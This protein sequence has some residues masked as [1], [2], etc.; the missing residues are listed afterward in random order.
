VDPN[1]VRPPGAFVVSVEVADPDGLANVA[2]V[3][4]ASAG[5][6]FR[7]C[8]DGNTGACGFGGTD[9]PSPSGD[10]TAGDGR[11]SRRFQLPEGSP[12][13][14]VGFTGQAFDRAG[15]ASASVPLIVTIQ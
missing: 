12:P 1:P 9:R 6:E 5:A 15:Q 10:A 13:G 4:L 2:R 7:L 8:D 14:D 3:V 11:F